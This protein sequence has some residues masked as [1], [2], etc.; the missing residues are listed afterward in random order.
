MA[1][2]RNRLAQRRKAR[3]YTQESFAEALGVDRTTVQRW[4]RGEVEPQPHQRPRVA[5]LLN[6]EPE[7][8]GSLLVPD[9]PILPVLG[10]ERGEGLAHGIR[11]LSRQ[12]VSLD[13]E[14]NGLPIADVAA[15]S[16]KRVHQRLESGNYEPTAERDIHSAAAELAEV[17]G[18]ALFDADLQGPARRFNQEALL[19]AKLSGDRSI[20]LLV[21][22]NMA[23]QAEWVGRPRTSLA[24][25]RTIIGQ[26]RMSPHVEAIFRVR[27]AK[28]LAGSG[29]QSEA[30][31]A[32]EHARSLTQESVR[33]DEPAWAWWITSD[34]VDGHQGFALQ[35]SGQWGRG[36][37]FLQRSLRQD[38]GIKVGY[39]S[40]TAARL[41]DCYLRLRAWRDAEE[42]TGS[43]IHA[44]D[45]ISSARALGLLTRTA[46]HGKENPATP[47]S[48]RDALDHIGL[49]MDEDPYDL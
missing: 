20:E 6:V 4:E 8:L 1:G 5:E 35:G 3:G 14:L 19:L 11:R 32:F 28:G 49:K 33:S 12:L 46:L 9:A 26:G 31:R 48:L 17:A 7:E 23:M 38:S 47:S 29:Q 30:V 15:R 36:V 2:R 40:I 45:E 41:L 13:N 34:E 18:W 10:E 27:E 43:I 44:I 16:F 39:R 42:L 24:I 37:P 21:M 25:A 22:Q